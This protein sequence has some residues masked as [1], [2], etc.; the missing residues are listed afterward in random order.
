MWPLLMNVCVMLWHGAAVLFCLASGS[1][2]YPPAC[3][4]TH[5]GSLT[6]A[7]PVGPRSRGQHLQSTTFSESSAPGRDYLAEV[8]REWEAAA[9]VSWAAV[10]PPQRCTAGECGSSPHNFHVALG[11]CPRQLLTRR[12]PSGAQ[13]LMV[14]ASAPVQVSLLSVPAE[15]EAQT[16]VVILRTGIV[17]AKEASEGLLI[18]VGLVGWARLWIT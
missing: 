16:R 11:K 7:P 18:W 12:S 5:P 17:L 14:A 13:L 6:A 1:H 15:Q 9:E 8:C 2:P 4:G 3:L 10:G